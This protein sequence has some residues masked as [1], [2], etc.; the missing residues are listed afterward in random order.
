MREALGLA[1]KRERPSHRKMDKKEMEELLRREGGEAEDG[2][3]EG[4]RIKGLGSS[5]RCVV[6]CPPC[7]CTTRCSFVLTFS[8]TFR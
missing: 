1:P 2:G 3:R 6:C 8:L 4:D 7:S 5:S